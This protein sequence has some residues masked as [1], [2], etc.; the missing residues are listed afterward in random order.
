MTGEEGFASNRIRDRASQDRSRRLRLMRIFLAGATGVI[1]VRLL[2]LLLAGGHRVAGMTRSHPE[3][4]EELGAESL[5]CDVYDADAL[6]AAV[7]GFAPELVVNE[8]TDLPDELEQ[9][10]AARPANRRIRTEGTR[11]LL[12][13]AGDV[14]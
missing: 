2:P 9:L 13:A 12:D 5:V 11:N 10:E 6:S 7:Q 3:L 1:G 8:L 4:V 14:K